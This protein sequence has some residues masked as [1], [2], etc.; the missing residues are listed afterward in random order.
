MQFTD[1]CLC[2]LY[3][4]KIFQHILMY[5]IKYHRR[6]LVLSL[7]SMAVT[8]TNTSITVMAVVSVSR[9]FVGISSV[10]SLSGLNDNYVRKQ[11]RATQRTHPVLG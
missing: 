4:Q 2:L 5:I 3:N 9:T 8:F 1:V 11:L 10:P 6:M 7:V